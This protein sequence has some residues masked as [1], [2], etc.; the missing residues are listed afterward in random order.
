MSSLGS[1]HRRL[2]DIHGPRHLY[3][4]NENGMFPNMNYGKIMSRNRFED[5]MKYLQLSLNK[6]SDQQITDF[7]H[8]VNTRFRNAIHPGTYLTLDESV[9]KSY[10]RN[11][12]GKL[13]DY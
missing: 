8:A 5:I 10:H 11:L 13:K 4:A 7:L 6:D 12:K 9:I 3:L 2:Y 1:Y